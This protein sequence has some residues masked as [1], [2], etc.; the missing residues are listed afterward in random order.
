[1][2]GS[3][4]RCAKRRASSFVWTPKTTKPSPWIWFALN[5]VWAN[6]R[7]LA[8][9]EKKRLANPTKG[10]FEIKKKNRHIL[11]KKKNLKIATFT[12]CVPAG[13]QN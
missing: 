13:R 10:F 6:F 8:T 4:V 2:I 1:M 11:T 5:F 12:Q 9:K 7:N 3:V